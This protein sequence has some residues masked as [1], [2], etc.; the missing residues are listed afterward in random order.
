MFYNLSM[1]VLFKIKL[2]IINT[3]IN[4]FD[5]YEGNNNNTHN[6]I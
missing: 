4:V 1:F 3:I 6:L 5:S 2:F